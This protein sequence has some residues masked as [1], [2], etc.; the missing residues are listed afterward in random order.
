MA[1]GLPDTVLCAPGPFD[2][3]WSVHLVCPDTK[4]KN[5]VLVKGYEYNFSVA[6]QEGVLLGQHGA[7]GHPAS[8]TYSGRVSEDGTLEINA[9]GATGKSEF[10]V[11]R[12]PQGTQY[13]Y[14]LHG[15][16]SDPGGEAT[17]RELRPCTATFGRS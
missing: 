5:G 2:G 3:R 9:T 11:G 13:G 8:V 10:A 16:L 4:D 12:V 6:I 7:P 17:R 15:K 1:A 14:T